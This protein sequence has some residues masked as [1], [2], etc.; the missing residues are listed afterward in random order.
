[1]LSRWYRYA[2]LRQLGREPGWSAPVQGPCKQR[3]FSAILVTSHLSGTHRCQK[4][5]DRRHAFRSTKINWERLM[6]RFFNVRSLLAFWALS[7]LE[8]NFLTFFQGLE[9]GHCD[10]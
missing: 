4:Y 7:Y 8:L 1:M 9:A 2:E 5:V 10:C 6:L 3:R